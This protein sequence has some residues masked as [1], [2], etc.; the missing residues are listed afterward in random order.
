MY[1]NF[2][3]KIMLLEA[4]FGE[5]ELCKLLTKQDTN[6]SRSNN[7]NSDTNIETTANETNY[8]YSTTESARVSMAKYRTKKTI[9]RLNTLENIASC[10]N[11]E[12]SAFKDSVKPTDFINTLQKSKGEQSIEEIFSNSI[13]MFSKETTQDFF[14]RYKGVY[15]AKMAWIR[16]DP[17]DNPQKYAQAEYNFLIR[18]YEFIPEKNLI[19]IE[20]TTC[21][22]FRAFKK[23]LVKEGT[24]LEEYDWNQY[25]WGWRGIMLPTSHDCS[26]LLLEKKNSDT[27]ASGFTTI[28][29]IGS[30]Y[31][32]RDSILGLYIANPKNTF[33]INGTI[34]LT[35]GTHISLNKF[36]HEKT[37]LTVEDYERMSHDKYPKN[38]FDPK[39]ADF[40]HKDKFGFFS[41]TQ[42]T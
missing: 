39:K 4:E 41:L 19:V 38:T 9:P 20:K 21:S 31:T 2:Y 26:S 13:N 17:E 10:L 28:H 29:I 42:Q 1:D 33:K 40:V 8:V 37:N 7:N 15:E 34:P 23:L 27:K 36:K 30:D 11:L 24:D 5:K 6:D 32:N 22:H 14:Y 3:L 12:I 35:T 16:P 18:I 25:D